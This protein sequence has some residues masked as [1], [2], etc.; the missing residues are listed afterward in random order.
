MDNF[1][2][3]SILIVDDEKVNVLALTRM[4]KKD[5][6]IYV[7]TSGK[8]ALELAEKHV[9]C[10][11]LLDILMPEMDGYEVISQLKERETTKHIPVIFITGLS[12]VGNEEKGLALGAVDYIIKPFS[13][14]IVRLRVQNQMNI[15]NMLRNQ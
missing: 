1:D 14:A 7:A 13:D 15:V 5:Y 3:N 11:I 4:L 12:N 2:K 9:P 8:A 6:V 10:V